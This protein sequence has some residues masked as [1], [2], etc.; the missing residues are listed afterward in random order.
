M[1]RKEAKDML[2]MFRKMA[3]TFVVMTVM[4]VIGSDSSV[5]ARTSASGS[6][7][8]GNEG[9]YCEVIIDSDLMRYQNRKYK[10]AYVQLNIYGQVN[11][12]KNYGTPKLNKSKAVE[13]TMKDEYNNVI[14]KG[15]KKSG[16][17]KLGNDHGVYKIFLRDPKHSKSWGPANLDCQS[18]EIKVISGCDIR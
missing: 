2:E 12:G 1:Y 14:W 13:I 6:F 5:E 3:V 17:L 10:C 15:T 7:G 4:F 16:Q 11:F 9:Q 8:N 18:W